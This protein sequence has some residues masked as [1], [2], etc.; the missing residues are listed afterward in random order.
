M[1]EAVNTSNAQL[2]VLR[3]LDTL[4]GNEFMG[5]APGEI[6]KALATSPSNITRDLRTLQAAGYAEQIPETGRWR[7]GPRHIQ[8][9]LAFQAHVAR[10]SARV[11][12][13]NQR[14][15]RLP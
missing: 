5:V 14:Y 1:T 15:T 9:A 13:I 7:C 4:I 8:H 12:E 10:V 3:V 2:R 6:A 11:E